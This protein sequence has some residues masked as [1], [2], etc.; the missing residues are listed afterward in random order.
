MPLQQPLWNYDLQRILPFMDNAVVILIMSQNLRIILILRD[1]Y[2]NF[3]IHYT[4]TFGMVI[5]K[6]LPL[7]ILEHFTFQCIWPIHISIHAK[8]WLDKIKWAFVIIIYCWLLCEIWNVIDGTMTLFIIWYLHICICKCVEYH[9]YQSKR[10][11]QINH[12][13]VHIAYNNAYL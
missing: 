1:I 3:V 11:V 12:H 2:V 4:Y 10:T 6:H 13:T 5:L 8:K 9:M 7:T